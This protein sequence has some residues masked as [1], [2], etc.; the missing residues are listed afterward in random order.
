VFIYHRCF[1]FRGGGRHWL[2]PFFGFHRGFDKSIVFVAF[3]Q[4]RENEW[5]DVR[6]FVAFF[7]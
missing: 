1:G 3:E 5:F 4:V 6:Y 2:R 7:N